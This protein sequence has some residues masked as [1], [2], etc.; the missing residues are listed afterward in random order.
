MKTGLTTRYDSKTL[1]AMAK[2][3]RHR[4]ITKGAF[5]REV[6]SAALSPEASPFYRDELAQSLHEDLATVESM[7]E[8]RKMFGELSG[9]KLEKRVEKAVERVLRKAG[10]D[11][12]PTGSTWKGTVLSQYD[13]SD[14]AP[15][16]LPAGG[17]PG[18]GES[19]ADSGDS[20]SQ[21]LNSES[22]SQGWQETRGRGEDEGDIEAGPPMSKQTRRLLRSC[23]VVLKK[24][25]RSKAS[26]TD[27]NQTSAFVLGSNEGIGPEKS[28]PYRTA[29][30][31]GSGTLPAF[32][33]NVR[34]LATNDTFAKR[35]DVQRARTP[36]DLKRLGKV[37]SAGCDADP[38]DF[39]DA[40]N[41]LFG[42]LKRA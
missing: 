22:S 36:E 40:M 7:R 18:S 20:D 16:Q 19:A 12:I 8:L 31:N 1:R 6:V 29:E 27:K 15:D 37:V 3:A 33:Q 25:R 2:A 10:I 42:T 28:A 34:D 17:Y 38:T 23:G 39:A 32:L 21:P 11:R 13:P 5:I 35:A 4:H 14:S 30:D 9:E 24:Q 41:A 26:T